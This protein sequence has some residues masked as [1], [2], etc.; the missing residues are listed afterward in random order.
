MLH[1]EAHE[2]G[3]L[4]F[5]N[6]ELLEQ[7]RGAILELMKSVRCSAEQAARCSRWS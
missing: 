1:S 4:A 2:E 3:G 5:T 6:K 7:Q